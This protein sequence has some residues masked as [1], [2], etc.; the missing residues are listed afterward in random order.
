MR[1]EHLANL[2]LASSV[3][4][5]SKMERFAPPRPVLRLRE[6]LFVAGIV[7]V[8]TVADVITRL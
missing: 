8:M 3:K 4:R 1:S 7:V 2:A 5:H 6:I